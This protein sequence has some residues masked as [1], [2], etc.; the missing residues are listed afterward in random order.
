VER[1]HELMH[2]VNEGVSSAVQTGL[3][4]VDSMSVGYLTNVTDQLKE[5][6]YGVRDLVEMGISASHLIQSESLNLIEESATIYSQ[7][8][9]TYFTEKGIDIHKSF[10]FSSENREVIRR[11][12]DMVK[13]EAEEISDLPTAKFW[14]YLMAWVVLQSKARELD[15][16]FNYCEEERLP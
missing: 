9:E 2:T 11:I 12:A 4:V 7:E 15:W 16:D 1:A 6:N 14:Q 5:F 10:A 13:R 3:E 8:M